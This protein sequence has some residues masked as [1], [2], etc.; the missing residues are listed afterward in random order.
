[1]PYEKKWTIRMV[2]GIEQPRGESYG[3]VDAPVYIDNPCLKDEV[4]L[5]RLYPEPII[6]YV[7]KFVPYA[8]T[9]ELAVLQKYAL[10]PI[11]CQI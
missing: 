6:D 11:E 5:V 8:A 1:V 3:Y 4:K 9:Y 7:L 10:C 2:I